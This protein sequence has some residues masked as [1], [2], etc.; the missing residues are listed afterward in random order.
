MTGSSHFAFRVLLSPSSM[1]YTSKGELST[2]V[3]A[4]QHECLS[5]AAL[6]NRRRESIRSVCKTFDEND[7]VA[8]GHPKSWK[9]RQSEQENGSLVYGSIENS[10]MRMFFCR[11][12]KAG[13]TSA[14]HFFSSMNADRKLPLYIAHA[15]K[16]SVALRF[17]SESFRTRPKPHGKGVEHGSNGTYVMIKNIALQPAL[18]RYRDYRKLVIV[19]HPLQRLV[20]AYFQKR[21]SARETFREFVQ[22]RVLATN[23]IHWLD[24]QSSCHPCL[25]EYDVV[26]QQENIDEEFPYFSKHLGL[27]PR[28]PYPRSN[29]NAQANDTDVYRYDAMFR[30]LEMSDATLFRRILDKYQIDMEMFGYYWRDHSSGRILDGRVC[31]E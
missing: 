25:M 29:V 23:N 27:N 15:Q 5:M 13:I 17:E 22:N 1:K 28:Y 24:Y 18:E 30:D 26:L 6:N 10:E 12:N 4:S 20:S 16:G 8:V 11:I 7:Q 2:V 19:R 14:I 3:N 21:T 31:S 9:G